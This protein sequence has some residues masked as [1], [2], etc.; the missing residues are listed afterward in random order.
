MMTK[1]LSALIMVSMVGT[2][3]Q[4]PTLAEVTNAGRA[5]VAGT[6]EDK[7]KDASGST[8][9]KDAGAA[10]DE[11]NKN[12]NDAENAENNEQAAASDSNAQNNT[13]NSSKGGANTSSVSGA[14][15]NSSS[16]SS[17][18]NISSSNTSNNSTSTP[19][20][21]EPFSKDND[22]D[23][24]SFDKDFSLF[25]Y[26]GQTQTFSAIA[27]NGDGSDIEWQ[28]EPKF[29]SISTPKVDGAKSTV[30][31]TWD[32]EKVEDIERTP[33]YAMLKSNPYEKI[34]GTIYLSNGQ[35]PSEEEQQQDAGSKKEFESEEVKN[36]V[37]DMYKTGLTQENSVYDLSLLGDT[38]NNTGATDFSN[39]SDE[40]I[41]KAFEE[42][43][44]SENAD[45]KD[46]TETLSDTK[47]ETTENTTDKTDKVADLDKDA[48]VDAD[49][50]EETASDNALYNR[51]ETQSKVSENESKA[52][53]NTD[54]KTET[55]QDTS[56]IDNNEKSAANDNTKT[57]VKAETKAIAKPETTKTETSDNE[58][59]SE[60]TSKE[61][62]E[63]TTQVLSNATNNTTNSETKTS[64]EVGEDYFVTVQSEETAE[65]ETKT[66]TETVEVPTTKT[67]EQE[68]QK[69]VSKTKQVATT[70][71]KTTTTEIVSQEPIVET[72][73]KTVYE[74]VPAEK[75]VT[76]EKQVAVGEDEETGETQYETVSETTT[77][78]STET[79]AKEETVEEQ[80]GTNYTVRETVT[81]DTTTR[82]DGVEKNTDSSTSVNEYTT[83]SE[84]SVGTTT[85]S[86]TTYSEEEI[87]EYV[88]EKVNVEVSAVE[89]QTVEKEVPAETNSQSTVSSSKGH[90]SSSIKKG[91][92][93]TTNSTVNNSKSTSVSNSS[94][95]TSSDKTEVTETVNSENVATDNSAAETASNDNANISLE[96]E[97]GFEQRFQRIAVGESFNAATVFGSGV[98][99]V[100]VINSNIASASGTTITAKAF[101][102]TQVVGTV[103]GEMSIIELEVRTS[104]SDVAAPMVAAGGRHTVALKKDGTV[105]TWG[106]NA[107]CE[108]GDGT[109]DTKYYPVQVVTGEQK[110]STGFLENIIQVAAGAYHNLALAKDGT[111]WAWGY[112]SHGELGNRIM[113]NSSLPV[114][115]IGVSDVVSIAAGYYNSFAVRKDGTVWS[116]GYNN[117][118]QLGLGDSAN[119][120]T[121]QQVLGGA[122]GSQYLTDIVEVKAATMHTLALKAN[123]TVYAWGYNGYGQLG[124]NGGSSYTPVQVVTGAQKSASGYLEK[125][126]DIDVSSGNDNGYGTSIAL[127]ESK[128]VYGWG[129]SGYGPLGQTGYFTSPIKVSNINTA[130]GVA[131]GGTDNTQFTYILKKDGTVSSLGY[132]YYGQL[133]NGKTDSANTEL[134][135]VQNLKNVVQIVGA[136][137]GHFGAAVRTDGTVWAWGYNGYGQLGNSK[138][139]NSSIPVSVGYPP[140]TNFDVQYA[141]V[142]KSETGTTVRKYEDSS[143]PRSLSGGEAI[144]EDE[145]IV[146]D[147]S[148]LI[149]EQIFGFNLITDKS[150]SYSNAKDIEISSFDETLFTIKNGNTIVPNQNGKYGTGVVI[151]RDTDPTRN[152]VGIIRVQVK[153]K[154][155]V[156]TPM[157]S[158]KQ[159][160]TVALKADGTVWTWGYNVAGQLGN[161]STADSLIPVQVLGGATGNQYLTNVVQVAAGGT[162]D[163]GNRY[164]ALALRENGT[165]WAWGDNSYGQLGIGVK[166]NPTDS[167]KT[168]CLTP[169]QVVTGEQDSSSTYLEDIIQISAGPTFAMALDRKGNVYTWGQ[170][171]VGQLGNN[172]NTD[173]NA[174]VRVSGGLAYTVY[175]DDVIQI[176]AGGDWVNGTND[177][178]VVLRKDGSVMTWGQNSNGQLG[179]KSYTS[180][181]TPV[182]PV[183]LDG[184]TDKGLQNVV[185][186][187]AGGV[188]AGVVTTDRKAYTWGY[189]AQRQ[190]G[191]DTSAST[192]NVPTVVKTDASTELSDVVEIAAGMQ[193]MSARVIE[194]AS[195]DPFTKVYAWG[196]NSYGQ[197]GLD[198]SDATYVYA[199]RVVGGETKK[200]YL[201]DTVS[202]YAGGYHM[203]SVQSDYSVWDWGYNINGQ[204]GDGTTDR[205][206]APV[207]VVSDMGQPQL[208]ISTA[209]WTNNGVD[210]DVV[211]YYDTLKMQNTSKIVTSI[212]EGDILSIDLSGISGVS[213]FN[214]L[215]ASAYTP[216]DL[217]FKSV[218]TEVATVDAKT[219]VVTAKKTGI[220]Y[221]IVT[222]KNG[223]EGF[224][225]LNVEPQG[226]NYIAYPQVQ[227][228]FDHTVALK[229]DGTVWAWGYN[230]HGN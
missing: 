94:N 190:L 117:Y 221:I 121:A 157:V 155:A 68:V 81:T 187:T 149:G 129:Y 101:G 134:R 131:L 17:Y 144:A 4:V 193:Q 180:S 229:A 141:E 71:T 73:T 77:V 51:K 210:N 7:A 206:K 63:T 163:G 92:S 2:S 34:T 222:D 118:G 85:D 103:N 175:L 209:T 214:L 102:R 216:D 36:F 89:T 151:I 202:L 9:S 60:V 215:R 80:V 137:N 125:V 65:P 59:L 57:D 168:S 83:T 150:S 100:K 66:V 196:N 223:A 207:K 84:P 91:N 26:F 44:N 30:D 178:A 165:V 205:R 139:E 172:T 148:K 213:S 58:K 98:S 8:E 95:A 220:T 31:I 199:T 177:F 135:D 152:F 47:T 140:T 38:N 111:V 1:V 142:Q 212:Q 5:I 170:N 41:L 11:D 191:V 228:G 200:D 218:D 146:I 171:N 79:V 230:A 116:W 46:N 158:A 76:V 184:N 161:N 13:E 18:N 162:F 130:V 166:G 27:A 50:S 208:T 147:T 15:N 32:K 114:K 169:M 6:T 74:E 54:S 181:L 132:N 70:T 159:S 219:G 126:V 203:G 67:V 49:K 39:M 72:K 123:G 189:N 20:V 143:M 37:E 42:K 96:S 19:Q 22:S 120:T 53:S 23:K 227:P 204:L 99:N 10:D 153:P 186:I 185:Q 179:N 16:S 61:L 188:S 201:E 128:E 115:V 176:A 43:Q 97:T 197:L 35:A 136:Q 93:N 154:D 119:R 28:V 145:Q 225:K 87:K 64:D 48:K 3:V 55:K 133:G 182:R 224:F 195:A 167:S 88:S 52:D 24:L 107:N 122:S 56:V 40:E 194:G 82:V 90:G 21:L 211:I 69:E 29:F 174:P 75:E 112:G 25:S 198:K 127:T 124:S 109:T 78:Q 192:V 105:W 33:F 138:N 45:N 160:S 156:A 108:L 106:Y 12:Q 217:T 113:S 173:S 110:S 104:S 86:F 183:G 14:K 62:T 226:T 164:Y